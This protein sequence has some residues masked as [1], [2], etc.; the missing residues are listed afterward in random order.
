M[1]DRVRQGKVRYLGCG[2]LFGRQVAKSP[3]S[4]SQ[5]RWN[6]GF[7]WPGWPLARKFVG[8]V[9]I[10]VKNV[11]QLNANFEN[12]DW[13]VPV[14]IWKGLE[15]RTRPDDDYLGWSNRRNYE[16]FFAAAEFHDE[17]IEPL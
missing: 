3:R 9:I 6:S 2:N 8:A 16:R 14:E 1:D 11:G 17:R 5:R 4:W 7:P 10:G 12:A 15:E 13:D